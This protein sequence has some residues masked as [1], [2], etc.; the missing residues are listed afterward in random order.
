MRKL[1]PHRHHVLD[2]VS[3]MPERPVWGQV[4]TMLFAPLRADAPKDTVDFDAHLAR[5][6]R[7]DI[8]VCAAPGADDAAVAGG[9]RLARVAAAGF[10]GIVTTARLRDFDEARALDLGLW[11][12][13]ESPMAGSAQA[14]PVATNVPIALDGATVMPGDII[15]ASSAGAVIIP[16]KDLARVLEL[17]EEIERADAERAKKA[18]GHYLG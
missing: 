10:R 7:A 16:A 18:R 1:H 3:P 5:A 13:G 8:L 2:L 4:A 15:H 11:C 9:I 6:G 14:M 12:R 17:A